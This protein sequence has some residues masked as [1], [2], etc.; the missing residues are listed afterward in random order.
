MLPSGSG[1][2]RTAPAVSGGYAY[3]TRDGGPELI[4]EQLVLSVD[5]LSPLA[6]PAFARGDDRTAGAVAGQPAVARGLVVFGTAGGAF[7]YR[8]TD[9]T[10][11]TVTLV[12]PGADAEVSG[13]VRLVARA[14]DAGGLE[15]VTFRLSTDGGSTRTLGKVTT[16]DPGGTF[17][18]AVYSLAFPTASVSNGGYLIEA[19]ATDVSGNTGTSEKR[20]IRVANA[21]GLT[22]LP[23][24]AC[25]NGLTGSDLADRIVGS[26]AGDR[27]LGGRG[28]DRLDGAG[29]HDC[30]LG[31]DG[32]DILSGGTGDDLIE[33]A[34]GDDVL[35]GGTGQNQ[36]D[37]GAGAD[38]A[39][40]GKQ[41][42]RITGGAG[43][44]T[45]LGGAGNDKMSGGAGND[46]IKG[47]SGSDKLTGG[48]GHDTISAGGGS[49]KIDGGTGNDRISAANGRR[50][51][52]VCGKGRDRVTADRRDR[53]SRTCERVT[54]RGKK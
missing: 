52:I 34:A 17:G 7:A 35:A 30:V 16:A 19:M 53:V 44:D 51:V 23:P 42:E 8:G 15:S 31:E 28:D 11:P 49:N 24:G 9:P 43:N 36:I 25:A 2:G 32:D 4:P 20:R 3:L 38:V 18:N 26:G 21:G 13:T 39:R 46:A 47:E 54:R 14:V 48:A 41:S 29:G 27:I 50:D 40:G 6:A 37:G 10:A 45:L 22:G 5:G 33:G 1:F 12:A